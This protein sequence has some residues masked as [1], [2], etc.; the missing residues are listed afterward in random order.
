LRTEKDVRLRIDLLE[1][2]SNFIAKMLTRA[3]S[4]QNEGAFSEYAKRLAVNRGQIEELLWVLDERNASGSN[5]VDLQVTS[6]N[7]S[8][9]VLIVKE[10]IERLRRGELRMD[11]LSADTQRMVRK[12]A[13]EIKNKDSIKKDRNVSGEES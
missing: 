11:D 1:G 3:M 13:L 7:W 9:S 8:D 12:W 2:Q 10:V 6:S 4:E 5:V